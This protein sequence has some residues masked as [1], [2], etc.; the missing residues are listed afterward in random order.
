MEIAI[1]FVAGTE[2]VVVN[3]ESDREVLRKGDMWDVPNSEHGV[4]LFYVA[5]GDSCDE[6]PTWKAKEDFLYFCMESID[7]RQHRHSVTDKMVL[8]S[9]TDVLLHMKQKF[10]LLK[11]CFSREA[12]TKMSDASWNSVQFEI[13]ICSKFVVPF[14]PAPVK[15][16][17]RI[18][19]FSFIDCAIFL[20]GNGVD[21]TKVPL[22]RLWGKALGCTAKATV[23]IDLC[24]LT[25]KVVVEE[26]KVRRCNVYVMN[27]H[28]I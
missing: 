2:D 20:S 8:P 11:G 22:A 7:E 10:S 4:E 13:L 19:S 28:L 5:S 1:T 3:L 21:V 14:A 9:S 24:L 12:N 6:L 15:Y 25:E 23:K 26:K 16:I 18:C 27:S 17:G